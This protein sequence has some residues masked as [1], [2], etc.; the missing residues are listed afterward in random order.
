[1]KI[2]ILSMQRVVNSGS[3]LQAYALRETLKALT[4]C[5]VEFIDYEN[6]SIDKTIKEKKQ[7]FLTQLL[8][9]IKHTILPAYWPRMRAK[10]YVK[11]FTEKW[12]ESLP[13][14]G[15]HDELNG[16][17]GKRYDLAIIGSDEVFNLCQFSDRKVDIPWGLL[18]EG[19]N[20]KRLISYAASCGQTT[21]EK[22]NAIGVEQRYGD[23]LKRFQ[24]VSVRDENTFHVV[25]TLSGITPQYH[26]DPVL[27]LADFPKEKTYQKLPYRYILIYAYTWRISSEDEIK[28]IKA[29][30]QAH[31]LKTVCINCYHPWCDHTIACTP[32]A[33]LQYVQDAEFVVSDT[34][35]GTVF[36]IR[37]NVPFAVLVRESNSK[38]LRFLLRQFGLENREAKMAE[39]IESILRQPIDF[40]I[41][42]TR[43][44]EE[45]MKAVQYLREQIEIMEDSRIGA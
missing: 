27:L 11:N 7:P 25:E 19:L 28:A 16:F 37:E 9:D 34:F 38:K 18:G 2:S 44:D 10:R 4:D 29:Y 15:L 36:S 13:A 22:L 45:R 21:L 40:S 31:R 12:R 26:I 20:A 33:L 14:L 5:E 43:L 32:F 3:L 39:E 23:L 41:V 30:A 17:Q 24:A 1:M 42:N 8:K 35:H 6:T